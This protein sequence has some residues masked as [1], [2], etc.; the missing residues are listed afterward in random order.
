MH[1]SFSSPLRGSKRI[2]QTANGVPWLLR[3]MDSEHL[4]VHF[5]RSTRRR[6]PFAV[7]TGRPAFDG[8]TGFTAP[9]VKLSRCQQART[10]REVFCLGLGQSSRFPW[11]AAKRYPRSLYPA[12][13]VPIPEAFPWERYRLDSGPESSTS[14]SPKTFAGWPPYVSRAP[15]VP[16]SHCRCKW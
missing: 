8:A 12:G 13:P 6:A 16:G 15:T 4:P 1:V 7:Q 9:A 14:S 2:S 5:S 11:L 3:R 10:S